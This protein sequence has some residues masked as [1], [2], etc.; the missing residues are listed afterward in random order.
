MKSTHYKFQ[1]LTPT[2]DVDLNSYE[3]ALGYVFQENDLKNVAITGPYSAGKSSV[4][5]TYKSKQPNKSFLNISLAHF[6]PNADANTTNQNQYSDTTLEG[7]ILNQLIHQIAPKNIP[8]THFK[9]KRKMSNFKMW[10]ASSLFTLFIMLIIYILGFKA[11]SDF[12]QNSATLLKSIF[13]F[14]TKE[15]SV[16]IAI[17]ICFGLLLYALFELVKMLQH[18]KF[19][20]KRLR[21]QGNEIEI[22]PGVSESYFDK[23]LNEVLYLFENAD[24][25]VIVFEDMDRFNNNHIFE[26]LREIN[27]L[28]NKKSDNI[29]RFFY[30]LRDDT[31]TSKDRTKFFDFIIPIVPIVDGSNSYDQFIALFKKGGI[32]EAFD[33]G[34]L[35]GLSLYIDDMRILKNIYNEYVIYHDRI[36]STELNCN[37]L[38]AIISYKNIFPRD[39]GELQLGRGFVH[40]LFA[41]KDNLIEEEISRIDKI[42]EEKW[43]QHSTLE[44]ELLV[45]VDEL[46]AIFFTAE[47]LVVNGKSETNFTSR[48]AFIKEMKENPENVRQVNRYGHQQYNFNGVYQKLLQDEDYARRKQA[49]KDKSAGVIDKIKNEISELEQKKSKLQNKRLYEIVTKENINEVFSVKHLNEIG[50]ESSFIDVKTS[51]YFPLTKYLIRNGYIDETYSDYMTYFYE[52]SLSRTDKIFLRSITD[53]DAKEF[54]FSLKDPSLVI[55]RLRDADFDEEEILNF[56]LLEYLL[57]YSHRNL[58][59]FLKQLKD[60]KRFDFILQ[61]WN[62]EREKPSFIKS[63]NHLWSNVF[64]SILNEAHFSDAQKQK[65]VV[66]SFYYSPDTDIQKLNVDCCLTNYIS[67][68]EEFLNIDDPDIELLLNKLVLLD[69]QFKQID[70]ERSDSSLF[71]A[72]YKS[73]L[74]QLNIRNILLILEKVYNIPKNENY[75]HKNFTLI[76]SKSDEPLAGYIKN[77]MQQYVDIILEYCESLIT[78][79]ATAALE[80]INNPD[81]NS[82]QK[83]MYISYLQTVIERLDSIDEQEYWSAFLQNRNVLYSAYNVL[84]YYSVNNLDSILVQF[85]NNDSTSLNFDFDKIQENFG[86]EKTLAFYK[87]IILC[88]SISDENMR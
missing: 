52:H 81:I 18:N 75:K 55:S 86:E 32:F 85:V 77:N 58:R 53:K 11:W 42:I 36:Q 16:V 80:I 43:S 83:S 14:S 69:V 1:K 19:T 68:N 44:S 20:L 51:P 46:D 25:E 29:I 15:S 88:D 87:E 26:K 39:F 21:V 33:K 5:E 73:E 84:E 76:V 7:K 41:N 61:Y 66:D 2:D 56:D 48:S 67:D 40:T 70:Y 9:V 31:F 37:K 34:F 59:R 71:M 62:T 13:A 49:I 27:D 3:S 22:V 74:Y 72:V 24:A 64:K 47:N 38:L 12:V 82:D 78:D 50:E 54:S 6:E 35:Q 65:Y 63:M 8:H 4:L 60:K 30:L 79:D 28:I 23:Y 45:D 17:I 10:V 57:K